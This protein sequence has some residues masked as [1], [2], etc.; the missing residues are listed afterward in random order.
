MTIEEIVGAGVGG[1]A[2][3]SLIQVAPI[4]LNPWTAIWGFLKW[5][6]RGFCKSLNAPVLAELESVKAA[7]QTQAENLSAHIHEADQREA[8]RIRERIL[9][10]SAQLGRGWKHT[11]EMFVDILLDIDWY[12]D[13][14]K[15]HDDYHN[16]RANAAIKHIRADYQTRLTTHDFA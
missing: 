6:W 1:I 8:S 5:I 10:F 15:N 3:L 14:C 16:S 2:I 4:K 7:Q 13:F 11:E 12:E 9:I